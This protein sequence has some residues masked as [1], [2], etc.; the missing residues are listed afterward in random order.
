MKLSQGHSTDSHTTRK[1]NHREQNKTNHTKILN[2][3]STCK[4]FI[5]LIKF[6]TLTKKNTKANKYWEREMKVKTKLSKTTTTTIFL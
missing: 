4:I 5:F 3:K 2:S 1:H 6:Y